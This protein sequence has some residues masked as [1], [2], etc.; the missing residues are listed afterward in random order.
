MYIFHSGLSEGLLSKHLLLSA[1]KVEKN[2][3]SVYLYPA[4]ILRNTI[5]K[6]RS[7]DAILQDTEYLKH[8]FQL[9][10]AYPEIIL[11][12]YL[13]ITEELEKVGFI[14]L[15]RQRQDIYECT[16]SWIEAVRHPWRS[17][18]L[19]RCSNQGL[20]KAGWP[21]LCS[22][23]FWKCPRMKASQHLWGPIW[24]FDHPHSK[25][26]FVCLFV[27]LAPPQP[28]FMN[29]LNESLNTAI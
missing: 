20:L 9:M 28:P 4:F 5:A 11:H 1:E 22:G 25:I 13:W 17:S 18:S 15:S 14:L 19:T 23:G 26:R 29:C 24:L 27:L 12:T 2:H 7:E 16:K 3:E 21:G 10:D 6:W 8:L